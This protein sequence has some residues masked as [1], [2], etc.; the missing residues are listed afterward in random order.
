MRLPLAT[1]RGYPS[2][3][4]RT[5]GEYSAQT[6]L[7]LLA[8]REK[9]ERILHWLVMGVPEGET[10]G[11]VRRL[12]GYFEAHPPRGTAKVVYRYDFGRL[13]DKHARRGHLRWK[14]TPT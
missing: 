11:A 4:I 2:R 5:W 3:V 8:K 7:L 10:R 1:N 6:P 13:V 9:A 14:P 12:R